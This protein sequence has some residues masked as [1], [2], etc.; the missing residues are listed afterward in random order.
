MKKASPHR[1]KLHFLNIFKK[2]FAKKE[3]VYVSSHMSFLDELPKSKIDKKKRAAR[4]P[5]RCFDNSRRALYKTKMT[6]CALV[7]SVRE[8]SLCGKGYKAFPEISQD[9]NMKNHIL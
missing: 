6:R 2:K 8:L 3:T 9:F 4:P 5:G 1:K 7:R